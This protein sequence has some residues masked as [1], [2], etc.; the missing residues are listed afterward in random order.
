MLQTA[1]PERQNLKEHVC[2]HCVPCINYPCKKNVSVSKQLMWHVQTTKELAL[3]TWSLYDTVN[4]VM[5]YHCSQIKKQT[6]CKIIF[7]PHKIWLPPLI[8]LLK[9]NSYS[10]SVKHLYD[11]GINCHL[12]IFVRMTNKSSSSTVANITLY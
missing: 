11:Y 12:K 5:T 6:T 2:W 4:D 1:L 7:F 8:W 3:C 9:S 10:Q